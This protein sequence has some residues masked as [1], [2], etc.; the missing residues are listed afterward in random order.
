MCWLAALAS[1]ASTTTIETTQPP[2]HRPAQGKAPKKNFLQKRCQTIVAYKD[3]G[4]LSPL[5]ISLLCNE[6]REETPAVSR[7]TASRQPELR[8]Q[9]RSPP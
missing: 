9:L 6:A 2:V 4:A 8:A 5:G 1:T 7:A 3:S